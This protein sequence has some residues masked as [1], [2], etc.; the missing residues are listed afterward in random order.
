MVSDDSG[1]VAKYSKIDNSVKLSGIPSKKGT[2]KVFVQSKDGKLKSNE[3]DF[4]V[5]DTNEVTLEERLVDKEFKPLKHS[6]TKKEWDMKPWVIKKF[7]KDKEEVTV[8]KNLKLWFGSRESG[9][10]SGLGG[11]TSLPL[12]VG[13]GPGRGSRCGCGRVAMARPSLVRRV[14]RTP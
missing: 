11:R 14:R 5:F 2:Y 7:G 4:E 1:M 12:L 6:D 8:P 3:L 9:K 13:P 10:Y